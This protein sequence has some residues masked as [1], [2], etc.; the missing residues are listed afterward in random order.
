ME[1]SSS[2]RKEQLSREMQ[3]VMCRAALHMGAERFVN[4]PRLRQCMNL[5]VY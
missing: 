3:E 5:C 4:K 1:V 2:R